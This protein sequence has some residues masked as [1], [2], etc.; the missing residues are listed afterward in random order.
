MLA[1][2][3]TRASPSI[4]RGL[5]EKD[6]VVP[7]WCR[8]SICS[9]ASAI[10]LWVFDHE[11][12]CRSC[13]GCSNLQPHVESEAA[14]VVDVGWGGGLQ[15]GG[16]AVTLGQGEAVADQQSSQAGALRV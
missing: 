6:P 9:R 7:D 8:W 13:V 14:V 3:T 4:E 1:T 11:P 15:Y 12:D 10:W 5:A 16:E 2:K